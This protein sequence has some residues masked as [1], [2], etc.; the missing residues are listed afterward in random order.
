MKM[1][2]LTCTIKNNNTEHSSVLFPESIRHLYS[3]TPFTV[4]NTAHRTVAAGS[5]IVH[6]NATNHRYHVT[7]TCLCGN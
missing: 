1:L 3:T 7:R 2:N 5:L 4:P 6:L